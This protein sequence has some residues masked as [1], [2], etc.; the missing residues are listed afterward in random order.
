MIQQ[1]QRRLFA[2]SKQQIRL[3]V[4][5]SEGQEMPT[6]TFSRWWRRHRLNEVV[7][8]TE[9]EFRKAHWFDLDQFDKLKIHIGFTDEDVLSL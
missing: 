4:G 6:T 9:T 3:L 2:I 8:M 1:K 5:R 7:N